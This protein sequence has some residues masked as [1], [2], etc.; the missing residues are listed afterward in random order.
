MRRIYRWLAWQ[1]QLSNKRFLN[2]SVEPLRES[3]GR[4]ERHRHRDVSHK[5]DLVRSVWWGA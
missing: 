5:V 2:R 4:A 3:G 1:S